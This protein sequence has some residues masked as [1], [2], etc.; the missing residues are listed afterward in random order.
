MAINKKRVL[1]IAL[2]I[3]VSVI[4]CAVVLCTAVTPVLNTKQVKT[5]LTR[6]LNDQTGLDVRF[7]QLGVALTP[8]PGISITDISVKINAK[9]QVT[10]NKALVELSPGPAAQIQNRCQ[11]HHPS[12]P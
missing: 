4:A 8:L 12:I 7:D 3:T 6:I 9:T 5:H 1:R 2:F 10:I 11:A